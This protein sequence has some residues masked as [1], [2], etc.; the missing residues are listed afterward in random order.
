MS[1]SHSL[2]RKMGSNDETRRLPFLP[3]ICTL[4]IILL[5]VPVAATPVAAENGGQA[6]RVLIIHSFEPFLPYATVVNQSI[7]STFE[8]DKTV[9]ADFYVEYLDLARFPGK[10]HRRDLPGMLAR[11]YSG[12]KPDL[13]FVMLFPALEFY[14]DHIERLFPGVPVIFCTV[15]KY[16]IEG[17][18]MKPNVTGVFM[19]I[20]PKGTVDTALRLEPRTRSLVVVGGASQNDRAFEAVTRKAL[21]AYKGRLDVTYETG[22]PMEKIRE[23]VSNLPKG[24]IILY[25]SMFQDGAGKSFVP[26]DAAALISRVSSVPVYGMFDPYFGHGIV[27]G[28][29]VSFEEQGKRAAEIGVAILRGRKPADLPPSASPNVYK[30][31]WRQMKRWGMSAKNLP[32]GS[33]LAYKEATLWDQ[34]KWLIIW[35]SAFLAVESLLIVILVTQLIMRRKAESALRTSEEK[36]RSIFENAVE[37][38]YQTTPEGRVIGA[39]PALARML[40]YESAEEMMGDVVDVA[41]QIYV[42]PKAR[43]EM[44]KMLEKS[45]TV[46]GLEIQLRRKDGE[47]I[48]AMTNARGVRDEKGKILCYEGTMVDMTPRKLAEEAV[49]TSLREKEVLLK[50]IH[51]RVKNNLQIMTSLLNLQTKHL[52]DPGA[53]EALRVSMNRIK[54]MALIHEK[55]YRSDNLS[56]I[57]FPVYVSD[58]AQELMRTYALGRGI[59]LDF[60]IAPVSFELN[61]AIPLGLILNE[62]V[63]NSLKHGFPGEMTGTI[64]IQFRTDGDY[65]TLVVSD[66]GIGF[67]DGLDYMHTESMGMQLVVTLV[68]QLEGTIELGTKQG[69]EFR[70]SFNRAP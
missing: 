70:I 61:T 27:G 28:D 42:D 16:Q 50:E 6:K 33:I 67:P 30:F 59:D 51:H 26:R 58:L 47:K 36:Y 8:S 53:L 64:A 65:A 35:I 40:G 54:T 5:A 15:E 44:G 19:E 69:T 7:R 24:T 41:E 20:D 37:G 14:L 57:F 13:V 4:L 34:H 56:S 21:S 10:E 23:I 29:L 22:R 11:K 48:W 55:L 31:D 1:L 38:I 52:S 3:L 9:K 45:G 2:P 39:N 63:S 12:R 25:T 49:K 46:E 18:T 43:E 62:L 68:E 17:L 60:D 66:T 32:P